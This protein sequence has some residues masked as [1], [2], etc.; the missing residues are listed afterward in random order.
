MNDI[1]ENL[2]E[3]ENEVLGNELLKFKKE[4]YKNL[5]FK[6]ESGER[7]IDVYRITDLKVFKKDNKVVIYIKSIRPG[8]VIGK[9]GRIINGLKKSFKRSI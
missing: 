3:K 4:I 2:I 7:D 1:A 8:I 9:Y 5:V 6:D